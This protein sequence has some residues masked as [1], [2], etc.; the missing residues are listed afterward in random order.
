MLGNFC[1]KL[2]VQNLKVNMKLNDILNEELE[3]VTPNLKDFSK[4]KFNIQLV[5]T[6]HVIEGIDDETF[7]KLIDE[8][9]NSKVDDFNVWHY[10]DKN[11]YVFDITGTKG[12]QELADVTKNLRKI[13]KLKED[14]QIRF[15][16]SQKIKQ[17]NDLYSGMRYYSSHEVKVTL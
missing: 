16:P 13:L 6:N 11:L 15:F 14:H 17:L 9:E 7:G 5:A 4:H 1:K 10:W 2:L 3:D 8:I 12:Y